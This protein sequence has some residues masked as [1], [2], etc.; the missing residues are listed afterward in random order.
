MALPFPSDEWIEQWQ[1]Q[2]INNEDYQEASEGWGVDFDG[3]FIFHLQADDRLPEDRYFFIGL[4]D[5]DVYDCREID[6]P[7]DV[8]Y[9]FVYRGDY[10]DWV[11]LTEGEVGAIDG[12]MSG[13]FDLDGD[14]QKVL[15]YSDAAVAMVETASDID[16]DYEF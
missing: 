11:R 7:D 5:G 14:M 4:E 1:E 16:T 9:G 3:D 8:D 12:M 10:A 6:D 13:V 15:Q 2:L